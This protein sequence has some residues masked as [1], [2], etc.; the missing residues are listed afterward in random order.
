MVKAKKNDII[1]VS[2]EDLHNVI[3][4]HDRSA[5]EILHDYKTAL[6]VSD[7]ANGRQFFII[8]LLILAMFV[9]FAYLIYRIDNMN[10]YETSITQDTSD[11]GYNNYIGNDGDM[12][13]E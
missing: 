3:K 6:S 10:T 11:G 2:E 12:T 7:K 9:M 4:T 13:N 8:I 5:M 1:A